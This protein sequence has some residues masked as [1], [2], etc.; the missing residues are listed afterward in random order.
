MA[1]ASQNTSE[2]STSTKEDRWYLGEG[3]SKVI[4]NGTSSYIVKVEIPSIKW[5]EWE[6]DCKEN[7]A[8]CRWAKMMDDHMKAKMLSLVLENKFSVV[9]QK[10]EETKKETTLSGEEIN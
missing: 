3:V 10:K 6:K 8:N 7:F 2:S 5:E 1:N 9:E 4:E